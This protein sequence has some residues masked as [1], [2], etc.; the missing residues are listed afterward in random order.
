MDLYSLPFEIEFDGVSDLSEV[1]GNLI[2]FFGNI[3]RTRLISISH[4]LEATKPTGI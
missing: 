2:T 1:V 4:Y 3:V